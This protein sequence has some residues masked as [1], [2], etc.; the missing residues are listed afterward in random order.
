[1]RL[2][3]FPAPF[4]ALKGR[5]GWPSASRPSGPEE[6]TVKGGDCDFP[7]PK[8]R[9]AEG[10]PD[11]PFR[12]GRWA[13]ITVA[14]LL[15]TLPAHAHSHPTRRAHPLPSRHASRAAR[16][17]KTAKATKL[18]PA[19]AAR[20]TAKSAKPV[21]PFGN[22]P[23][24]P[25]E[26]L[27][28]TDGALPVPPAASDAQALV[29]TRKLP[30]YFDAKNLAT[31][32]VLDAP[33]AIL[34]DADTGQTL[35]GK[36][37]TARR[38]PASTT[39]I[40]TSLIFIEHTM[41][42]QVV[43]CLDPNIT[44][45]EPSSLN[46]KPWEKF[47][48]ED[49]LRG[50][51]LRSG[52]DGAVVMAE[53]VAGT[54]GKFADLMNA[55]SQAIGATDSHWV[56]PNGLHDKEH[57]TTVRDMA[58]IARVALQNPRFADAVSQPERYITRS[59]NVRD[60]H[61]V[62]HAKKYWDKFSG[63]DGVK[64]GYTHQAGHCFVGTAT[65]DGRRLMA[66]V[67]GARDSA[68]ADTVPLL[69]WGFARWAQ[70]PLA[71]A[72]DPEATVPVRGG[73]SGDVATVAGASLHVTYD[74]LRAGGTSA[75]DITLTAEPLPDPAA[76]P[77]RKGD[78]VGQLIGHLRGKAV[79]TVPLL[80]AS[81][82]ARSPLAALGGGGSGSAGASIFLTV[83]VRALTFAGIGAL[84]LVAWRLYATTTA[85][86]ARRR[87]SRLATARRGDDRRR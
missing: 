41:P 60:S 34:I 7:G 28:T 86:S 31:P 37:P 44:R 20:I 65:R 39:K 72:G 1:M 49:L 54:V 19:K 21:L 5:S 47:T 59:V 82:V 10:H 6:I 73:L 87:R 76:A 23:I 68:T 38:E 8:G 43:T 69:G 14:L 52:N 25:G 35:W 45:I 32:P 66:V 50:T 67:F 84:L 56:T 26:P 48:A 85:K 63:A 17:A 3:F 46:I 79:A 13:A 15:L 80:A 9:L 55:R 71:R 78:V 74:T 4:P 62:T 27:W 29:N 18:P 57:Y 30:P 16:P 33:S 51:L 77:I 83:F 22:P 42:D 70:T 40:L 36:N 58:K 81:D 53:T 61:I 24:S 2:A 12:A 64:T 11:R 75:A